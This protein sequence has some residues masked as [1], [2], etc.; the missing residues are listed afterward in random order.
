MQT[1]VVWQAVSN[2]TGNRTCDDSVV[3]WI[4]HIGPFPTSAF[5]KDAGHIGSASER[6]AVDNQPIGSAG[7]TPSGGSANYRHGR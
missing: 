6:A 5:M 7:L 1:L 2:F 4:K 3:K